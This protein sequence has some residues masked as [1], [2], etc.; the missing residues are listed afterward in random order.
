[1]VFL[2]VESAIGRNQRKIGRKVETLSA[3]KFEIFKEITIGGLGKEQLIQRLSEAGIQFNK[4][5]NTLFEHPQF[6]PPS[7]VEKVKLVKVTLSDLR[8]K[9]TCSAEEFSNQATMLGLKM[10]PLYLA[11]FLRLEYL[12][13]PDG[14]YLTIASQ[15]LNE[16]ENFPNGFYLRN[17]ENALWLRGYRADGFSD[18]PGSN[19]FI[20]IAGNDV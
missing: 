15:K 17:F 10:C 7:K 4:Y 6:S 11:A 18:W 12:N 16:D 20:F 19:E 13:Q 9:D 3:N 5:A 8:L 14:P 1:V 2:F